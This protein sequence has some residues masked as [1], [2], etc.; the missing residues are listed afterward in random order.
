MTIIARKYTD[1]L[2]SL[3]KKVEDSYKFFRNNYKRFQDFQYFTYVTTLSTVEIGKLRQLGKPPLEF[4]II[5]AFIS[6]QCGEFARHEPGVIVK[7]ADGIDSFKQTKDFQGTIDVLEA[8]LR[9]V[10][11]NTNNDQM[12]YQVYCDILS[13]GFSGFEV[14]TDYINDRSML[15]NIYIQKVLN[16]CLVGF[17]PAAQT[18]HKGDGSY[19]F[20]M[21]P[22]TE[23]DFREE[24]DMGPGNLSFMSS[25]TLKDFRWSYKDGAKKIILVCEMYKKSSKKVTI[26]KI[27]ESN[28]FKEPYVLN[29]LKQNNISPKTTLTRDEYNKMAEILVQSGQ[30]M[31]PPVILE[32]RRSKTDN[33]ERYT[34]FE[35]DVIK[36][37]DT[38]YEHLP[39]I[40]VDG[41]SRS[42]QLPNSGTF[43]QI[44]RP[45]TYNLKST[46]KLKNL[47]GQTI[48]S[49]IESIQQTKII[50]PIEG[51]PDDTS[52][53]DAYRNPQDNSVLLYKA[54]KTDNPEIPV[55]PPREM[56]RTQTPAIVAQTFE[57]MTKETQSILGSYDAQLGIQNND[58]SGKAMAMGAMQSNAA[59]MPYYMG[60]IR[61]LA[62]VAEVY[63]NLFPKYI[64]T[65]R[66]I[67]VMF[68]NGKREYVPINNQQDPEAVMMNYDPYDL[69]IRVEPGASFSVQRQVAL[70]SLMMAMKIMPKFNQFMDD[71]GIEILLDNFEF[72]GVDKVKTM[73]SQWSE[74]QKPMQQ[75]QQQ[76]QQQMMQ[77]DMQEK[78]SDIAVKQSKAEA[79][80]KKVDFK[81]QIEIAKIVEKGDKT[82]KDFQISAGKL[83]VAAQ[84]AD[85]D[86]A[87][88]A[89]QIQKSR[90]DQALEAERI[91]A[92]NA[93]TAS[94]N[95]LKVSEHLHN[96]EVDRR[97]LAQKALR[98]SRV[99][100]GEG[101]RG[102]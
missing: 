32:E 100:P 95:V 2:E 101:K 44:T 38:N 4:N 20:K 68:G 24:F 56:Q 92:E 36:H 13:G 91:Q 18:S 21:L 16:P 28:L 1:E 86:A 26:V 51:L 80:H 11:L 85:I 96:M 23:E 42:L 3:K 66:T 63:V 77:L 83:N 60:Y 99:Y 15:K 89:N 17:D 52:L 74:Q 9:E 84:E 53:H 76:I 47:C 33:I 39:L 29:L 22:Y 41:N 27:P 64:I 67:P 46:Q 50:A 59:S 93:R 10:L 43:E 65:P 73:Y 97:N 98:E 57:M 102:G 30:A 72:R 35:R 82:D 37:D 54:F 14:Y 62:R 58:L 5:E 71:M 8:H 90:V 75:Q 87:L 12:G 25:S 7:A 88:A 70:E 45:Y 19:A 81:H 69:K 55:P 61:G 48:A 79:E 34:F 6:R 31:V 49:E 78:Q 94:E 40:F